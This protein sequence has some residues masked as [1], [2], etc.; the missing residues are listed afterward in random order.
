MVSPKI[1]DQ[2]LDVTISVDYSTVKNW[3]GFHVIVVVCKQ[4][5]EMYDCVAEAGCERSY[6][7]AVLIE[8][9]R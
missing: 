3:L 1:F 4:T 5:S 8:R 2:L 9:A 7:P 6:R